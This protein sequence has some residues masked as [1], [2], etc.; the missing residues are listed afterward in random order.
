[1][2]NLGILLINQLLNRSP[3][4]ISIIKTQIAV[5][6]KEQDLYAEYQALVT[7][8][9]LLKLESSE[10]PYRFAARGE[11]FVINAA[12]FISKLN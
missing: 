6:E 8:Y 1:M 7:S 10:E 9:G 12:K 2:N 3:N 4:L 5:I 11:E